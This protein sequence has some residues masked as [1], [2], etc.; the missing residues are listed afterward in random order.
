MP[1]VLKIALIVAVVVVLIILAAFAWII[2]IFQQAAKTAS[3]I[4]T[5]PC[6]VNLEPEANPQWHNAQAIQEYADQLKGL[7]F[8]EVGAFSI[9]E[10][11]D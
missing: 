7:G 9:P 6:R 2:R 3:G 1:T 11:G 5:L 8:E 10:M 4:A